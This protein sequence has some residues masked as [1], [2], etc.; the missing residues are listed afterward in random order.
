[1]QRVSEHKKFNCRKSYT[2]SIVQHFSLLTDIVYRRVWFA[3]WTGI[4]FSRTHFCV[5]TTQINTRR[6]STH[7][8]QS[9]VFILCHF[10]IKECIPY[11]RL[12]KIIPG[13]ISLSPLGKNDLT[14][15]AFTPQHTSQIFSLID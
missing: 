1:M 3:A 8:Y 15:Y 9:A 10:V 13:V 12:N 2:E 11:M 14:L 6:V 5:H 4:H 7:T